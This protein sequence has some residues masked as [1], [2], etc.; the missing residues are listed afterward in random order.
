MDYLYFIVDEMSG[1]IKIGLSESPH[2]RITILQ[3][4]N[5]NPLRLLGVVEGDFKAERSL[6]RQWKHLRLQGEWFRATSELLAEVRGMVGG[7]LLEDDR[8]GIPTE[9]WA[10]QAEESR[11]TR[12][13]RRHAPSLMGQPRLQDVFDHVVVQLRDSGLPVVDIAV[14][15]NRSREFIHRRL[16]AASA[17]PQGALTP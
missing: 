3:I 15:L 16:K 17:K 8:A 13:V 10:D 4:G 2:H 14:V 1:A 11:A 9:R 12:P 5:P 6:H 7:M